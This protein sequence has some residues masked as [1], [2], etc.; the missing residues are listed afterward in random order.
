MVI[1]QLNILE[2]IWN[3]LLANWVGIVT[4]GIVLIITLIIYFILKRYINRL[5]KNQKLPEST[6]K[7][8]IKLLKFLII[9]IILFSILVNFIEAVSWLLG[10]FAVIGGAVI[11]F[12]SINTVGNMI[13]GLLIM[14]SKPFRIDDYIEYENRVLKVDDIKTIYTRFIDL[15]GMKI[16]IPNQN[17]IT[18]SVINFGHNEIV[19]RKV[20]VTPD[21]GEDRR[22]VETALLEAA[23]QIP[24]ILKNPPASVRITD[25]QNFAVEYTLLY[26]IKEIRSLK[27]IE[28]EL[29]AKIL[30]IMVKYN[31]DISTP[32]IIRQAK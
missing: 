27:L 1:F 18:N 7:G 5:V 23:D 10:I 2:I 13:A 25:F 8:L 9:L 11:G 14:T 3:W 24:R 21:F 12:A 16:S 15:D 22:K 29:R 30:D 26:Y 4:I 6:A 31:I 17:L 32:S 20:T 19:R 28:A